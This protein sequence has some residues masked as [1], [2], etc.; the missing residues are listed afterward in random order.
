MTT[1]TATKT[2][3]DRAWWRRV[4]ITAL[5]ALSATVLLFPTIAN[6]FSEFGYQEEHGS[7][8][9]IA[10]GMD[11]QEVERILEAARTYNAALP[12]GPL[13][14]PYVLNA[15]GQAEDIRDRLPEYQSQLSFG[16][17]A[18][19]GWVH[20]PSISTNLP[21]YH[22]TSDEVLDKGAG[23][24]HGSALPVGGDSSHS[25]I[26]AHSGRPQSKLFSDLNKLNV[27][28][29][30]YVEVLGEEFYYRVVD[31]AVVKPDEGNRLRRIEGH[32]YITLIT[33]TPTGIN[34]HRLLVQGERIP[35]PD[36]GQAEWAP[37]RF[38]PGFPW[39]A[40]ILVATTV[41][42]WSLMKVA[43]K[44][45][46]R[47]S[48]ATNDKK[49]TADTE[50]KAGT[51]GEADTRGDVAAPS[52]RDS[53]ASL[54]EYV[55]GR[56]SPSAERADTGAAQA[57]HPR[58]LVTEGLSKQAQSRQVRSAGQAAAPRMEITPRPKPKGPRHAR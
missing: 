47:T 9:K 22:G 8:A 36:E 55:R 54:P 3:R 26:S 12:W 48:P 56:V 15:E 39:W 41:G 34:S 35:N 2:S 21:V 42:T 32:D 7:Y 45:R 4:M 31:T 50:D 10:D 23:H 11:S 1:T 30:F 40:A 37:E 20:I 43:D 29:V 6:W 13:R 18:P 53:E 44:R 57:A 17:D 28:D 33:C 52:P 25:V 14:D 19:M 46:G 27:G 38:S 58:R 5:M 16:I 24:L 51:E 49:V